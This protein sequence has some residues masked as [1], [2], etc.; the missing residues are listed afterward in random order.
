[1]FESKI[2]FKS[3]NTNVLSFSVSS[4]KEELI[5][6][7][8]SA[9]FYLFGDIKTKTVYTV[10]QNTEEVN[11]TIHEIVENF[12]P[13]FGPPINQITAWFKKL[14][15]DE[16]FYFLPDISLTVEE[17]MK[18]HNH[19]KALE[20][21]LD[22]EKLNEDFEDLFKRTFENY[23]FSAFGSIR[24]H[25]GVKDKSR[26]IC[27]FCN[28]SSDQVTF[29]NSAHAIPE[30]LGNKKVFL[31]EECDKCNDKFSIEIEPDLIDHFTIFRVFFNIKGKGGS[32][33][34]KGKN[35]VLENDGNVKINFTNDVPIP[36]RNLPYNL[37]FELKSTINPQDV[38]RCLCKFFI[39]VID[40]ELLPNFTETIK[41]INKESSYERLPA[42]AETVSYHHFSLE[43]K[44]FIYTRKNQ[45]KNIPYAVVEFHFTCTITVIIVPL[46]SEDEKDFTKQEDYNCFWENF[47]H[48]KRSINWA[49]NDYS[50]DWEKSMTFNLKANKTDSKS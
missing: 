30:A 3:L 25:I 29:K 49:F 28:K 23:N 10:H 39:S 11:K 5:Q 21:G 44:I 8:I 7:F 19:L 16:Y 45:N 17:S 35:F 27:R 33:K 37:K 14:K 40:Y 13:R 32:K 1:M 41:W 15:T 48:Y 42:I 20:Q 31:Y 46:S 47:E 4:E 34:I 24:K 6:E 26:R 9:L 2:T 36:D 50:D 38:Y 22:F 43:P 18:I 12:K